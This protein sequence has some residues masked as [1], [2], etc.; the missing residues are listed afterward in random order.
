MVFNIELL[1]ELNSLN[2]RVVKVDARKIIVIGN[3]DLKSMKK[4]N[5]LKLIQD[6]FRKNYRK[7]IDNCS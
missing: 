1:L 3:N 6:G 5:K 2:I 4:L 7:Y